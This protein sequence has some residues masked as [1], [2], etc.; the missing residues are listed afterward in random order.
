M[1]AVS[2]ELRP[3]VNNT[4]RVKQIKQAFYYVLMSR[5][6]VVSFSAI[7]V[8]PGIRW[9]ND[10]IFRRG[11]FSCRGPVLHKSSGLF[12]ILDSS[13]AAPH[14]SLPKKNKTPLYRFSEDSNIFS[15]L[16]AGYCTKSSAK[17]VALLRVCACFRTHCLISGA[18]KR[19][20]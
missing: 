2:S 20:K 3:A 9:L 17:T 16:F 8:Q 12:F 4:A 11:K 1:R 13:E 14:N 18:S 6:T 7:L 10:I 5:W 19:S 15:P